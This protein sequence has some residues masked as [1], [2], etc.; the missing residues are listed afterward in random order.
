MATGEISSRV[1]HDLDP[2]TLTIQDFAINHH[3]RDVVFVDTPGFNHPTKTDR[4]ILEE[5][6]NWLKDKYVFIPILIFYLDL[7]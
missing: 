1:G 5:I 7:I 3:G 6:V 2:C 4:A